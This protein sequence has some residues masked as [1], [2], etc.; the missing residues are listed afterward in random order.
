[1]VTNDNQ[2]PQPI[3]PT[4]PAPG[5]RM[6][7]VI[8][9]RMLVLPKS[10]ILALLEQNRMIR[11]KVDIDQSATFND[12]IDAFRQ[13]ADIADPGCYFDAPEIGFACIRLL[14]CKAITRI[15]PE[16]P[17]LKLAT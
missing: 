5:Q 6:F 8:I 9:D 11:A 2:T 16:K 7:A 12:T 4:V 3:K 1:M 10:D 13:W 14:N 17:K 15:L